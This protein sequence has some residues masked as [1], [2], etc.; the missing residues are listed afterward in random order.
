[1]ARIAI[2][3]SEIALG[4]GASP[5]IFAGGWNAKGVAT[6]IDLVEVAF[7]EEKPVEGFLH[8]FAW[9]APKDDPVKMIYT[10]TRTKLP[11]GIPLTDEKGKAGNAVFNVQP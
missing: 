4:A 7:K 11:K 5:F 8:R 3:R 1:M 10:L 9:N 2:S 6:Q